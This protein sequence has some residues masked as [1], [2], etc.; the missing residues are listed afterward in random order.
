MVLSWLKNGPETG[1]HPRW[2][3]LQRRVVVLVVQEGSV[4]VE[5]Q[6]EEAHS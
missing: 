4:V 1:N 2:L 3:N 5:E 6:E